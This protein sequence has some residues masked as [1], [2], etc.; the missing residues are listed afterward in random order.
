MKVKILDV[1]DD[2]EGFIVSIEYSEAGY[3]VNHDFGF[4]SNVTTFD[5][6]QNT[7]LNFASALKKTSQLR[8]SLKNKI[9]TTF[10]I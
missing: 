2:G 1:K 3:V 5:E 8:E 4:Y 7:I 10:T 9:G 6:V